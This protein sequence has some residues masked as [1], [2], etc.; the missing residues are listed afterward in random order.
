[1]VHKSD[2]NCFS[3]HAIDGSVAIVILELLCCGIQ[4]MNHYAGHC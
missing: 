3:N 1:M 2:L 4:Q